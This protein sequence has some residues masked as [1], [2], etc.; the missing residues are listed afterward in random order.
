M[1]AMVIGISTLLIT[2]PGYKLFR[3][4]VPPKRNPQEEARERLE[5]A[6]LEAEAARLNKE[7]EKLYNNMYEEIDEDINKDRRRL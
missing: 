6:R 4:I 3:Q 1:T 7:T 5:Q 2:I